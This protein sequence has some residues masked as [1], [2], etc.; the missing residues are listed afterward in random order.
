[1]VRNW[2][3]ASDSP[4]ISSVDRVQ[5]LNDMRTCL[6]GDTDFGKFPPQKRYIN[7]IP[8]VTFQGMCIDIDTKIQMYG[9]TGSY[10][11][12]NVG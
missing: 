1:M 7:G 11:V 8:V 2:Y 3:E 4:G 6:L 10:N 5:H 9:I 12:S